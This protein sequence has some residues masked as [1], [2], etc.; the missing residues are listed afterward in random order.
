MKKLE[1]AHLD[2][3]FDQQVLFKDANYTF[4]QGKIYGLLGRNGSG[5][6]TL[7]NMI[8]RNLPIDSGTIAVDSDDGQGLIT[9]YSDTAVGMVYTQPHLP[10]FM[11]GV[12]FV[13]YF[14]AINRERLDRMHTTVKAADFFDMAG[15]GQADAN[16]LLRDYS[17]GMRNKLQIVVS[18]ML[19]PPVLL[20]DEPLTTVDVVA[21]HEMQQ[22]IVAMKA[23]SVVVFSTH[24]MQLAQAICDAVVLL[25]QQQL[26]ELTGLDIHSQAFED[27]VI[28]RLSDEV[29]A[30][31]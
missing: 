13:D 31:A 3:A 7:F 25:H 24:I 2:K 23:D 17:E 22:M 14:I 27:A 1:I 11:T 9:N 10:A 8:V 4:Q 29:Q 12:E 18:L 6:S 26:T 15:L 16:K 20:L 19:K 30:D 21:A 5:K 28:A